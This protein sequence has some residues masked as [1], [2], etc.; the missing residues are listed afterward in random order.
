MTRMSTRLWREAAF[1]R[2]TVLHVLVGVLALGGC[3]TS[4][5]SLNPEESYLSRTIERSRGGLT[6]AASVLNRAEIEEKFGARMDFV[7]IQPVWLRIENLSAHS[8][9][10][11]LRSVD[12]DYFSPYEVARRTAALSSKSTEEL[13]PIIR[14]REV[15]RFIPPGATVEGYVYTHVDEGLKSINVDLV[16]N[17]RVQSFNMAI[18]VPGLSTDYDDF[19]PK[20]VYRI[21]VPTLGEKGL[22]A[23]LAALPCCTASA[24]GT[25][26]DP[27][28]LV[29]VGRID[30]IR[31]AL[32]S[33]GWDVTAVVTSA[34]LQ[35]IVS[36]FVFGSRYRYA[37][38]SPLYLFGR[39]QDMTFQKARALIDERNHIRLWLAPVTFEGTPVWVGHI[40]RDAG[41]KFS[42]RFWP[43]TTHIID[44]AVD[45]ARF[46]VEQDLLY[47]Q[48]VHRIGLV[49]GIGPAPFDDPRLNAEGDPYFTDGL[50]AVFF[51]GRDLIPMD[52]LQV[53]NWNLPAQL[54]PFRENIFGDTPTNAY[55]HR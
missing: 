4:T 52:K 19:D 41:L 39:E 20:N 21:P 46:Y 14:D 30:D 22:R 43:P 53:L 17:Q 9:V 18:K 36:A 51:V 55:D 50:R 23:W 6:T 42:G 12:P 3:T 37:P 11:F 1:T 31:A 33:Q 13:Y 47:S 54:E 7:G 5:P 16:G 10:L 34:S 38:I 40:S 26:G 24:E 15:E 35:R 8:Y 25:P 48:R 27:L 45:E 28:N 32:I 2:F 49:D 29:M 44:P